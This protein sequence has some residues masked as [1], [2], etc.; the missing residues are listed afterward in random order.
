MPSQ[1]H[2]SIFVAGDVNGP[3]E[4]WLYKVLKNVE[5]RCGRDEYIRIISRIEQDM[6]VNIQI[7]NT[8][9]IRVEF[10]VS[11]STS[12]QLAIMQKLQE[13]RYSVV[14]HFDIGLLVPV[15]EGRVWACTNQGTI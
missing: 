9:S 1:V 5:E 10:S 14:E 6:G 2:L 11:S 13:L 4:S 8:T 3:G 15:H 7:T 12:P